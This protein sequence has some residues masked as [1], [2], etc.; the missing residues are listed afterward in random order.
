MQH[1]RD[2]NVWFLGVGRLNH[3]LTCYLSFFVSASLV[4]ATSVSP[5]LAAVR[6]NA[7]EKPSSQQPV[8]LQAQQVDYDQ[9]NEVV[10]ASGQVEVMQGDT[11]VLA[12]AMIYDLKHDQVQAM[13][14]VI[15]LEPSGHVFFASAVALRDDLKAGV[16]HQFKARLSD[17]SVFVANGAKKVNENIIEL[18]KAAYT[19][20]DCGT[21]SHPKVPMWSF[22]AH[23]A[24][25]DQEE[26]RITYE[27][28]YFNVYGVPAFYTPYLSHP[29]PEAENQS[30]LLMPELYQSKNLGA[31][32]KQPVYYAIAPDR[33]LTITPIMTTKEGPV[34]ATTYRQLFDSGLMNLTG[35][36][37]S[38]ENRDGLGNHLPGHEVRGHVN[39]KGAFKIDDFYNW[40]FDIQ[41]ASDDT[42][43]HRYN[44]SNETLLNSRIYTEGFNFIGDTDRNYASA[45]GLS[46]QGLTGQDS[47]GTIPVVA[48][49]VNFTWQSRPLDYYSRLTFDANTMA[50][51]RSEGSESQRLSGTARWNLPYVTDNGQILELET[52]MRTDIYQVRDVQ[53]A[54]G[55]QFDGTTGRA[56]PQMS[57]L[58]R[59]PFVNRFE[60]ASLM[61]EPVTNF[62]V[63]PGGGNPQY[64]PNEDSLLPDFNDSNLFSSNR[65]SG[66][67]RVE[68]GPRLSYGMRSQLQVNSDKYVDMLLGQQYRVINDPNFPISNDLT[69]NFS[70]YVGKVD[71]TYSPVTLG[72]RF[73]L[74]RT[75]LTPSRS[76]I[77]VG[78]YRSPLSFNM[79]YLYLN[80]DPI[81][82]NREVVTTSGALDLTDNW[83]VTAGGSRDIKQKQTVNTNAGLVYKNECVTLT[84]VVGKDYTSLLDIKPSLSFWFR[85]S[86]KNLD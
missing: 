18:F 82:S 62:T 6:I 52:Q 83:S 76:E 37:T 60:D 38:A 68:N 61:V 58:W 1:N 72:Y 80:H 56:I 29:T 44:F 43:L 81:L 35:S 26:Q 78:Y 57:L 77:G 3:R 70:D 19:P 45:E 36:I 47:P 71:V 64:I 54:N 46:F 31:V 32:Y 33:D 84:T 49:L 11:I 30:G 74:D 7:G 8:L 40:G 23:K 59:Y 13:G 17:N 4:A 21:P 25:I 34:L 73:R 86:L 28:A 55:R 53:L 48:P 41:R 27:D 42:Y 2:D 67:D 69:S 12:D 79:A 85:V 66:Y 22:K 10:Y 63:S 14:N 9:Q 39:A 51:F 24:T 5:A 75:D 20:C 50:L 15:M 16:I 65:F